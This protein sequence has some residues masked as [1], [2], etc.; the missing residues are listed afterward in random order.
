MSQKIQG[1]KHSKILMLTP[2][3]V[4]PEETERK[5]K[6]RR[7]A[8]RQMRKGKGTEHQRNFFSFF[9]ICLSSLGE[10]PVDDPK[11][12]Q[13]EENANILSREVVQITFVSCLENFTATGYGATLYS[14]LWMGSC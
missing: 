8:G 10:Q 3:K 4:V 11:L 7:I 13:D 12:C 1:Q 14:L 5:R 6:S 9:P 2:R